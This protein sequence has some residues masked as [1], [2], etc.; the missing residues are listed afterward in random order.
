MIA[1]YGFVITRMMDMVARAFRPASATGVAMVLL[2]AVVAHAQVID[3][4]LA[5]LT[6]A[7]SRLSDVRATTTL[8]LLQ[9]VE[10]PSRR[11]IGGWNGS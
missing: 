1:D 6:G 10:R 8:G 5:S 3:R 2:A 7:W 9:A 11:S 4:V